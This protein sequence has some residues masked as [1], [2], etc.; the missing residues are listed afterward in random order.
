MSKRIA[1]VIR[2]DRPIFLILDLDQTLIDCVDK[3]DSSPE[4]PHTKLTFKYMDANGKQIQERVCVY[5]RPGLFRFLNWCN[6]NFQIIIFS[7]GT[8][9]YILLILRYFK[10]KLPNLLIYDVFT[11]H[12]L[13]WDADSQMFLKSIMTIP[14]LSGLGKNYVIVDDVEQHY[15]HSHQHRILVS[16]WYY[17]NM[18][19]NE[20]KRIK[21]LLR[22][23]LKQ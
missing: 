13:L 19:D 18:N 12:D 21:K 2:K 8:P 14:Y 23:K 11:K 4:F 3:K 5:P 17:G 10:Y 16:R 15:P 20:L 1:Y 9:A 6:D 7:A 22:T